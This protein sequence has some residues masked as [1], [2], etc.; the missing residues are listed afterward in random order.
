MNIKHKLDQIERRLADMSHHARRQVIRV[1]W[2]D[3]RVT[4]PKAG[5]NDHV[6]TLRVVY[7]RTADYAG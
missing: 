1:V 2:P 7:E 6:V 5:P 3:G 4:G